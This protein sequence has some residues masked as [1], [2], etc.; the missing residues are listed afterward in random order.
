MQRTYE[1]LPAAPT[2]EQA[3]IRAQ[4]LILKSSERRS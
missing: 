4:L 2:L 3:I 1:G